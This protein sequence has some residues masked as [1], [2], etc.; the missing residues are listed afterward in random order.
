MAP[1]YAYPTGLPGA[2]IMDLS[3]PEQSNRGTAG[4]LA[5]Y[6]ARPRTLAVLDG[7]SAGFRPSCGCRNGMSVLDEK[8]SLRWAAAAAALAR[9]IGLPI[10]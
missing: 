10:S 1:S 9:C 6:H 4:T 2:T 7:C 8:I 5:D 3:G